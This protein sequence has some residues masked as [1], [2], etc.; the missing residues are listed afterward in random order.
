MVQPEVLLKLIDQA[1][2]GALS[3]LPKQDYLIITREN[4]NI[5]ISDMGKCVEG[6]CEIETGRNLGADFIVTGD[7]LQM[8]SMYVLTLKMYETER[9]Q[10]L[11]TEEVEDTDLFNLKNKTV[12]KSMV[13]FQ[14]LD[15]TR[16][17]AS[18][19]NFSE[20]SLT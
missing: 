11:S 12:E 4:M 2:A 16:R 19:S 10:L 9:G 15:I 20:V 8:G 3:V 7:I 13:L 18:S 14:G 1:R 17:T 5:I 6:S